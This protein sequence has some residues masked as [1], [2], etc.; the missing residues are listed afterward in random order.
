MSLGSDPNQANLFDYTGLK[1]PQTEMPLLKP[2]MFIW[3]VLFLLDV[4]MRRVILDFRAM[5][6]R[7][8]A[9]AR[10]RRADGKPDRTLERLR[11]RRQKLRDQLFTRKAGI[12]ASR[13]YQ[14]GEE[15]QGELPVADTAR[16][17]RP[18]PVEE[19]QSTERERGIEQAT[20]IQRLLKAK[21]KAA[22]IE[23]ND[24]TE[25]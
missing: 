20:H 17:V 7:I 21:R 10:L 6:R 8:A 23:S 13:R 4:A 16:K 11:A 12:A 18:K 24:K 5:A 9:F 2:L 14:A 1:F 3:L 22:G 19:P 25:E 15:Y